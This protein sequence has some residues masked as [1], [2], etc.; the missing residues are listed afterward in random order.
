MWKNI[1]GPSRP[2]I[3]IWRVRIACW[4]AKHTNTHTGCVQR[5]ALPLK[6]WLYELA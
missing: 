5:I 3:T 6:Q 2:Q 4:I 1:L